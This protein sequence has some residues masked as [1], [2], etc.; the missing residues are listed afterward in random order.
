MIEY[1]K[2]Y[3][4]NLCFPLIKVR[5]VAN[6]EWFSVLLSSDL[7]ESFS[8][9]LFFVLHLYTLLHDSI[10]ALWKFVPPIT[11]QRV[12]ATR[13]TFWFQTLRSLSQTATHRQGL[14]TLHFAIW[15]PH[16]FHSIYLKFS[17]VDGSYRLVSSSNQLKV[18]K[19]VQIA[20]DHLEKLQLLS[21]LNFN[22]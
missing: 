15:F 2:F 10:G 20:H 3:L 19:T 14:F 22:S 13:P 5:F 18:A 16:W 11:S 1:C 9:Y 8:Y 17:F 4:R 12:E 21:D 6:I 7:K